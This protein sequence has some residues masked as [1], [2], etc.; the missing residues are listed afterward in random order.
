MFR[1]ALLNFDMS[2]FKARTAVA[3]RPATAVQVP[4]SVAT[5]MGSISRLLKVM[6]YIDAVD[7][8]LS[9]CQVLSMLD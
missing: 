8:N 7:V 5:V 9:Y 1:S 3:T 2:P 6:S 4:S